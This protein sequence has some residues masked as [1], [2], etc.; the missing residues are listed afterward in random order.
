[1]MSIR[2]RASV[3]C[4]H[5]KQL[6][7][8]RLQDPQ[9]KRVYLL[10]PGGKIEP[11]ERPAAAALRETKE[12]TGF[13]VAIDEG[14]ETVIRYPFEWAGR[15]HDC[16]THFFLARLVSLQAAP[17]DDEDCNLGA[18]WLPL[19]DLPRELAYHVTLREAII[20]LVE[21]AVDSDR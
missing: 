2:T 21:R 16:T 6:L 12:E 5:R 3:L 1:M 18:A 10:P 20:Q 8:V 15:V 13:D 17:I 14:S 4:V 9:T 7:V 19:G 11:G